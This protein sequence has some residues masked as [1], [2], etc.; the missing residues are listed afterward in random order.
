MLAPSG[1]SL[2]PSGMTFAPSGM[3]FAPSGMTFA[4]SG[5]TFALIGTSFALSGKELALRGMAFGSVGLILGGDSLPVA[6]G[7]RH[8][9]PMGIKIRR[10]LYRF[11]QSLTV[12]WQNEPNLLTK[13]FNRGKQRSYEP[14]TNQHHG[15][16]RHGRCL[17]G[18]K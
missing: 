16:A 6:T 3:T 9:A 17:H 10:S 2:A 18:P 1:T 12:F 11:Q 15:H 13:F 4:P 8:L 7:G 14:G 5:M